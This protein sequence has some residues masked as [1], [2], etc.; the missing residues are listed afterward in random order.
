MGWF[1]SVF[2]IVIG[3]ISAEYGIRFF[4]QEK[5]AGSFR[6]TMLILGLSVGIWQIGYGLIGVCED[7][8]MCASLRRAAILGVT[9][10]P[11][12]ETNLVLEMGGMKKKLRTV[13]FVLMCVYGFIDWILISM[14]GVDGFIRMDNWTSFYAN[15]CFQ[16]TFHNIYLAVVFSTAVTGWVLWFK[17]VKLK[18]EKRLLYGILSANLAIMVCAVPDTILIRFMDYSLPTSGLGAGISLFLW[19]VA[20]EKYNT[21]SVSS[22]TM[23]NYAQS[24]LKQGIIIFDDNKTVAETNNFASGV[25][26]IKRG[27]TLSSIMKPA[28][29][30]EEIRESLESDSYVRFKSSMNGNDRIYMTDI[31]VARD[32]YGD[33]YGYIMTMTDITKEEE[34][35]IEAE[36]ANHAKSEFLANMSHE[37][38]TPMNTV[39][40]MSELI[41]SE[42]KDESVLENAGM[43]NT[44]ATSLLGII[45]D[46]L[47]LSK[48]ESGKMD[49]LEAPYQTASIINDVITMIGF[50]LK[51]S[52]VKLVSKVDPAL[53]ETL[54]G[55][56]I[57]L[58]QILINLLGNA[59]KFTKEGSITLSVRS[60]KTGED[61]CRLFF[62]V[63]DTG[64]GIRKED[65]D[66]IFDSFS[67]VDAK[68]KR[69]KEGTGLGL[70]ISRRLIEM[71]DGKISVESTFGEGTTFSFE[72]INR[73]ASWTGV[74]N[75]DDSKK[76]AE[77]HKFKASFK[78]PDAKVLVVDDNR[79]N[80]K[81]AEG[82]LRHYDIKPT[83]VESGRAAIAC[84]EHMKHFDIIFMDHMMPEM[85]GEE[86]MKKIRELDGGKNE[87]VVAL[88]ANALTGARKRYTDAGFDDFLAK[89]IEPKKMDDILRKY[90]LDQNT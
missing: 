70:A 51:D 59:V 64:T 90:L 89:P 41:L 9:V 62:D 2:L 53:P 76:S 40:G 87:I 12:V 1:L 38:R 50:R 21:F 49:I 48:I 17:N 81:V 4:R 43:I 79:M 18:R 33:P 84:F 29:T 26:G 7:F 36:S 20:A 58:K 60:E 10:Y 31:T 68:I 78:A 15:E 83:C 44:A 6:L 30:D 71:M 55:D 3:C 77:Q 46:I 45:N 11:I 52:N 23:G 39:I 86:T 13:I 75:M 32:D 67:Q 82:L 34:L 16:R 42:S 88:T 37:I 63:S 19:Y 25:L 74:G 61:S 56:E 28:V 85:D 35:L 73:V 14:P 57:R 69:A 5:N 80:L 66:K 22:K 8:D 24:I 47:D 54:I 65:L 72:I 27:S